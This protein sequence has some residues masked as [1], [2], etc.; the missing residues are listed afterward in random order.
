M[1]KP[2]GNMVLVE[3]V[4]TGDKTT[5]T[6]LVISA[7]FMDQGPKKGIIV[8]MGNGEQNYLGDI[9]PIPELKVGHTVFYPDHAGTDIE[10]EDGKKY[11]LITSKNILAVQQ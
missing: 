7:S 5:S 1:I 10:D 4:E 2:L 6:G 11:L 8:A 3:K 9:I